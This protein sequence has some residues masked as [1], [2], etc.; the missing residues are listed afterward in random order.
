[1]CR[2][3]RNIAHRLFFNLLFFSVFLGF[4]S[5]SEE[6]GFEK[7]KQIVVLFSPTGLGDVGYNDQIMRGVQSVH[8]SRGDAQMHL[9]SP[10][11]M[12]EA[13]VIFD[14][15]MKSDA[16]NSQQ[17]LMVLASADYGP[18]LAERLQGTKAEREGKDILLFETPNDD[19]LD[20]YSFQIEMYG[21]SYLAGAMVGESG[22]ENALALLSN[23]IDKVIAAAGD[24]FMDGYEQTTGRIATMEYLHDDWHGYVMSQEAYEMMPELSQKYQFIFPVAGG[25]NLGIYRYLRENPDGPLVAGMDVD[26]SA[27][28]SR[29]VGSVVKHIDILVANYLNAWI[30]GKPLER[31]CSYGLESGYIDWV[32]APAYQS[33]YGALVEKY[34]QQ[35]INKEREY[36]PLVE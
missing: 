36:A 20:V 15:W 4:V 25:T 27:Y 35:A 10:A 9:I 28:S 13:G 29:I 12:E 26:Q 11:S 19:N 2:R 22:I 5:C 21:A 33:A 8:Y 24:G 30:D 7:E 17:T 31:K 32:L 18:F 6:E 34:R 14:D 1:M 3:S 23:P 16:S